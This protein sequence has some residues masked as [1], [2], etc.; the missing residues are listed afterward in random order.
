MALSAASGPSLHVVLEHH[1]RELFVGIDP[2]DDEDRVALLGR[3]L[4]ERVLGLEVQN[5]EL[6]DPRRH[7]QQRHLV[8]LL[9]RRRVLDQLHDLILV[10]DLA[11]G[12][13][14]VHADLEGVHVGLADGELALAA[15]EVGQQVLEAFQ[16]V[17][18]LGLDGGLDDL[19][20]CQREV[21]RRNGIDELARVEVHLLRG[22]VV[23]T[24]DLLDRA[25][26][27]AG[28]QQVGLLQVVED[29][30]VLPGGVVEA[31]V[32]AGRLGD[33]LRRLA[34]HALGRG[35]PE[36][37]V[38][39][40]QLDLGLHQPVRIGQHLGREVHEGLGEAEWVG[41]LL[42]VGLIALGKV[43]QQLL[44][45]RRDVLEC[46]LEFLGLLRRETAEGCGGGTIGHAFPL[47]NHCLCGVSCGKFD[48]SVP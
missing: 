23:D 5:V 47:P 29:D 3:P 10:D 45:A 48:T 16:Q 32:A 20:I 35:L 4:D 14:D 46:L 7:D 41:R 2:G 26:Q 33:G 37:H 25:L 22:L 18:A 36:L 27:P 8:D 6:V 42:T 9:G 11:W 15:L 34:H 21:R 17:L 38:L 30:L 19:G 1:L 12:R 31:L 43:L 13:G 39:L 24:L 40:P 28:G 44:A